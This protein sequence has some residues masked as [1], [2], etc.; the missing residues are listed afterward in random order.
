MLKKALSPESAAEFL[1]MSFNPA[2]LITTLQSDPSKVM[3][4][5][6]LFN[7]TF[8]FPTGVDVPTIQ[9]D[10]CAATSGN[11]SLVLEDIW[12]MLDLKQL[13]EEITKL[14]GG[15]PPSASKPLTESPFRTVLRQ[16]QRLAKNASLITRLMQAFNRDMPDIASYLQLLWTSISTYLQ[17]DVNNIGGM[18]DA[19]VNLVDKIP[20][21]DLAKPWLINAQLINHI[22]AQVA[23]SL[24]NF[25]EFMCEFPSMNMS[26]LLYRIASSD[27]IDISDEILRVNNQDYLS[28]AQFRCSQLI[29]DVMVP[30]EKIQ[31]LITDA[32]MYN[33]SMQTCFRKFVTSEIT[34]LNDVNSV[35]GLLG[36]LRDLLM[37]QPLTGIEWLDQLRPLIDQVITGLLGQVCSLSGGVNI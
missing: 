4:D 10:L 1:T 32:V 33:G 6:M 26:T 36:G 15:A 7:Q 30:Q 29:H 35:L 5:P 2:K 17:P 34:I 21:F 9:S 13:A 8:S 37:S 16:F 14:T 19:V 20:E 24:D 31:H 11:N 3:C 23:T 28:T 18:C 25:D 27:L 12:K 22:A